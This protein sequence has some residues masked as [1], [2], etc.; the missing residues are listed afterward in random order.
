MGSFKVQG[1]GGRG[2]RRRGEV[3]D[4][5][6]VLSKF[7]HREFRFLTLKN[8]L[9]VLLVRD[10]LAAQAWYSVAVG[11]GGNNDP[12][13]WPQ[14]NYVLLYMGYADSTHQELVEDKFN[15]ANAGNIDSDSTYFAANFDATGLDE[16]FT[17]RVNWLQSPRL[18]S[19]HTQ[20]HAALK[21]WDGSAAITVADPSKQMPALLEMQSAAEKNPVSRS[22]Q[23]GT[24]R[25]LMKGG[26][27]QL[28][29]QLSEFHEFFY[30]PKNMRLVILAPLP[31]QKMEDVAKDRFGS[32]D[33]EC[34][35]S[36]SDEEASADP[37]AGAGPVAGPSAEGRCPAATEPAA[38]Q[39]GRYRPPFAVLQEKSW[40][41]PFPKQNLGKQFLAK[42]PTRPEILILFPLR[43]FELYR[44]VNFYG[45]ES[46]LEDVFYDSDDNSLQTVLRKESLVDSLSIE[47]KT[48]K[49]GS[50]LRVD[51]KLTDEADK[52]SERRAQLWRTL[53][54][55]FQQLRR[56]SDDELETYIGNMK[57]TKD[58]QFM[59]AGRESPSGCG[60]G[61]LDTYH[62]SLMRYEPRDVV[63]GEHVIS[64]ISA[65]LVRVVL[66]SLTASNM[67]YAYFKASAKFFWVRLAQGET[68]ATALDVTLPKPWTQVPSLK[69]DHARV[70]NQKDVPIVVLGSDL[71][72]PDL[73]QIMLRLNFQLKVVG[74]NFEDR[75][76]ATGSCG[77]EVS[78]RCWMLGKIR[79]H[80]VSRL[81]APH[82][83]AHT[84]VG[85]TYSFEADAEGMEF[86][87]VAFPQHIEELMSILVAV[88]ID[89]IS[90]NI[91]TTPGMHY[92]GQ[93][94]GTVTHPQRVAA[95]QRGSQRR[96]VRKIF[97]QEVHKMQNELENP[98]RVAGHSVMDYERLM[99]RQA[100][101]SKQ[102]K[103]RWLKQYT[104]PD[105]GAGQTNQ[106]PEGNASGDTT[107]AGTNLDALWRE[108]EG[109]LSEE[110]EGHRR[111]RMTSLAVGNLD[112]KTAQSLERKMRE[113]L[114]TTNRTTS[115]PTALISSARGLS[116]VDPSTTLGASQLAL[117]DRVLRLENDR[118]KQIEMRVANPVPTDKKRHMTKVTLQ[119]GLAESVAQEVLLRLIQ[120][121]ARTETHTF[122]YTTA[123]VWGYG[124][125]GQVMGVWNL[126]VQV[127]SAI[128]NPD[129]IVP[130]IR[131]NN[132][133]IREALANQTETEI[134]HSARALLKELRAP[135]ESVD[136]LYKYALREL[137][138]RGGC[139]Q[140]RRAMAEYLETTLI[141]NIERERNLTQEADAEL[142]NST[143]LQRKRL[144]RKFRLALRDLLDSEGESQGDVIEYHETPRRGQIRSV[145]DNGGGVEDS[146]QA[147]SSR[148]NSRGR[149]PALTIKLFNSTS[150]HMIDQDP[151]QVIVPGNKL[152]RPVSTGTNSNPCSAVD[153]EGFQQSEGGP[154]TQTVSTAGDEPATADGM[155][156]ALKK[157]SAL[158][159][160]LDNVCILRKVPD[161]EEKKNMLNDFDFETCRSFCVC[162]LRDP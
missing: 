104:T 46:Y 161:F 85:N 114:T 118:E 138:R 111:F 92:T 50:F 73:E 38:S 145:A 144:R 107:F 142:E 7:D 79:Q 6:P 103:V 32:L 28:I 57:R 70:I 134:L 83:N 20:L 45:V 112:L 125:I 158:R 121:V 19:S 82:L 29:A 68:S 130:L 91:T 15:G 126:T 154:A 58:V 156:A 109:Y 18:N 102:E 3:N 86:E 108:F 55:W 51:L 34:R 27:D 88:A 152:V 96:T 148:A 63:R 4:L 26:T 97:S 94:A 9:D 128:L 136:E 105:A 42:A 5:K 35:E 31:L 44:K 116:L 106:R 101:F 61:M 65:C 95:K 123:G 11:V 160:G 132:L 43:I 87:F 75:R 129:Q 8:G 22:G 84:K 71:Y 37:E 10:E 137:T 53:F 74:D 153:A 66:E 62:D 21:Y 59:W 12:E 139:F 39:V 41:E 77:R 131:E 67:N 115:T 147:T 110:A 24:K 48:S 89:P 78:L 23:L 122:L 133:R 150:L 49:A 124:A 90:F 155:A 54:R 47:L 17:A 72:F 33:R 162:H 40:G 149:G 30:C 60:C 120:P 80:I 69:Q 1:G 143:K 151:P 127:G 76:S 52:D 98:H 99:T 56:Q 117:Q 113:L 119:F 93:S 141:P 2:R 36:G 81:V 146:E 140:R 16:V 13:D 25:T 135:F 14:L 100:V 64:D 159:C 157:P